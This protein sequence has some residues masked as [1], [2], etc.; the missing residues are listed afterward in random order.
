MKHS[1]V[2]SQLR[3]YLLGELPE[4]ERDAMETDIFADKETFYRLSEIEDRLIDDYARGRMSGQE[5]LN[6]EHLYLSNP[7]RRQHVEFALTL[8]GELDRQPDFSPA[9]AEPAKITANDKSQIE[10]RSWWPSLLKSLWEPRLAWTV[11]AA[12]LVLMVTA[13]GWLMVERARLQ[14]QLDQARLANDAAIQR[15]HELESQLV[16]AQAQNGDQ[17]ASSSPTPT[18][19]LTGNPPITAQTTFAFTLN[20][21]SLRGETDGSAIRILLP[22]ETQQLQLRL[23]LIKKDFSHYQLSLRDGNDR[24]IFTSHNLRA[25]NSPTGPTL[26]I[27]IPTRQLLAGDYLLTLEG[28]SKNG[29]VEPVGK[30]QFNI[31]RQ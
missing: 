3:A 9:N 7:A 25:F 10:S 19:A 13:G 15:Q 4:A 11:A 17:L 8:T 1:P 29:E 16:A 5:K 22:S 23:P 24:A 12:S 6:F 28:V 31:E 14:T 21:F 20:V 27:T 30:K 26:L 2:D 18:P